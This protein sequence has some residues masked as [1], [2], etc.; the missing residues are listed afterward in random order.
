MRGLALCFTLLSIL[1]SASVLGVSSNMA[2]TYLPRETIIAQ[3]SENVINSINKNQITLVKDGHI[4]VGF[5]YDVTDIGGKNFVWLIAPQNPG[6]Y[7]L[8]IK[9]VVSIENGYPQVAEFRQDFSVNGSLVDYSINPGFVIANDEFQIRATL[10]E[11]F[12]KSI[13]VDF[14][15]SRSVTLNPGINTIDFPV[16]GFVGPNLVSINVGRYQVPGIINGPS[17]VCGDGNIDGPEMCDGENL[18]G[19]NCSSVVEEGYVGELTCLNSCLSFNISSCE[20]KPV[21]NSN[22]LDLCIEETDCVKYNGYWYGSNCNIYEGGAEC[23]ENHLQICET[24]T[25]CVEFNGYWYN[26]KCNV[27]KEDSCGIDHLAGCLDSER[28][29]NAGGDWDGNSCI[30]RHGNSGDYV[31]EITPKIINT[32]VLV[33]SNIPNYVFSIKNLGV[34]EI[35]NLYLVFNEGVIEVSPKS[36]ITIG[37]NDSVDFNITV[38]NKT[39]DIREVVVVNGGK[40]PEYLLFTLGFTRDSGS[41]GTTYLGDNNAV[42]KDY[43]IEI[44]GTYG[45]ACSEGQTCDGYTVD[46]IDSPVCCIGVCVDQSS[47]GNAWIGYLV[48]AILILVL[49]I[50]YTKYKKAGKGGKSVGNRFIRIEKGLP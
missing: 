31:F 43:C 42:Q 26:D 3:L 45:D 21:C 8:V 6:N 13:S 2:A 10:Y 20:E 46:S 47:G 18:N 35:N 4:Q 5:E 1:F 15:E 49:L 50:I 38:K 23:D 16:E 37:F 7:T 24:A 33:D 29:G 28:C 25:S 17:Y 14:P 39:K 40:V 48:A 12:S 44:P 32:K 22:H 41:T 9:D 19:Q 11:S 27:L 34:Y 30:Q 36:N